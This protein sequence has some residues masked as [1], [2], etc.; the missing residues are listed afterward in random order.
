MDPLLKDIPT[1]I[2][3]KRLL[4]RCPQPGDGAA[5]HDAIDESLDV[6]QKWFPWAHEARTLESSE[7][8]VRKAQTKFLRREGLPFMIWLNDAET[9]IG[10]AGF[11]NIDWK[12]PSFEIGYWLRDSYTGHGYMTEAVSA[13]SDLAFN[14]L[15]ARRVEILCDAHNE[16]SAAIAIR[17]GFTFEARHRSE[18]L[19]ARGEKL[20]DTLVFAK[21][22]R[23]D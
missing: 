17:M 15:D 16:K 3:T 9:L 23:D 21:Y 19:D 7:A 5:M 2:E 4:L 1:A 12:I 20:V 14:R 6:F 8:N 11:V 13:L 22:Q 10:R 18:R